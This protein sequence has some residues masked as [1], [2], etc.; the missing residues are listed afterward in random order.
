[1]P[2]KTALPLTL[3]SLTLAAG[4]S[5][6]VDPRTLASAAPDALVSAYLAADRLVV[7]VV[8][9]DSQAPC[10]R[11]DGVT[12]RVNGGEAVALTAGGEEVETAS[13]KVPMAGFECQAVQASIPAP[14]DGFVDF[15]L[16]DAT[17]KWTFSTVLRAQQINASV[18]EPADGKLRA[19]SLAKV[20]LDAPDMVPGFLSLK[21]SCDVVSVTDAVLT[22]GDWAFTVP[23]A[24][25][26]CQTEAEVSGKL[27]VVSV[28]EICNGP[29]EC[30]FTTGVATSE[31]AVTFV[32]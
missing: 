30:H 3:L 26:A 19:G 8:A 7:S 22:G 25:T 29:Q 15:E 28:R 11:I 14:A 27:E 13:G 23:A 31:L 21:A 6:G 9:A 12:L 2:A 5:Q 20:R 18:V 24:V 17:A 10:F 32:K 4:C 16:S 1:M